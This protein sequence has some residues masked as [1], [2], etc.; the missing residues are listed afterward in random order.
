QTGFK[1][2]KQEGYNIAVQIDADGQHI[3]EQVGLLINP[4]LNKEADVVIGS[5]YL[6]R[7][8][9]Y[10]TPL[11]RRI[12]MV[13]FSLMNSLI[14][15][16]KITDNTSGFRAYNSDAIEFLSKNYPL[17]FPEVEAVVVLSK[18]N[19]RIIETPVR[20]RQ[21][22]T[23]KSSI[24]S[25]KAVYYMIKVLLGIFVNVFRSTYGSIRR[26]SQ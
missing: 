9:C 23:G 1:Y 22:N 20:M 24:T 8:S 21:R 4:I 2:A 10:N 5:R 14:I 13:I 18:N 11:S 7:N 3:P 25:I 16:Q 12:G 6:K 26:K 15:G 19:F 17:D